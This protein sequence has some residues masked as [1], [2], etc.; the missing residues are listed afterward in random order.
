[1]DWLHGN[2]TSLQDVFD[3]LPRSVK[4]SLDVELK[5]VIRSNRT[6]VVFSYKK[7]ICSCMNRY[8]RRKTLR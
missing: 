5:Y 4:R 7:S 1:M 2:G 3:A 8:L 6:L